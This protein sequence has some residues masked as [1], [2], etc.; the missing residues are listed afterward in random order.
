MKKNGTT[1]KAK[2]ISENRAAYKKNT[3]SKARM[4][5][6][7]IVID[8]AICHGKPTFRGTRIM[9]ADV[10]EQVANGLTLGAV[11][12]EWGGR[13]SR[14]AIKEAISLARES[15]LDHAPEYAAPEYVL[16]RVPA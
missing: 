4:L 16:E 15:F 1:T 13:I 5:G 2:K 9:V 11:V 14:E 6:R 8:P 7:Y 10:L 12:E 3:A